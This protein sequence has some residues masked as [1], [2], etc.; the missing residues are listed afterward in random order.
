[1]LCGYSD[2]P[3]TVLRAVTVGL[4]QRL[5]PRRI[6][7]VEQVN[8]HTTCPSS[9]ITAHYIDLYRIRFVEMKAIGAIASRVG[10]CVVLRF[11]PV[12]V[13]HFTPY[14]ERNRGIPVGNK[15]LL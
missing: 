11:Q 3:R 14:T 1:M 15:R 7:T 10:W 8:T 12:L 13:Q 4:V 2:R 9:G 6:R 5:Y